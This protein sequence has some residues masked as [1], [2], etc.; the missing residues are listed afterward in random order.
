MRVTVIGDSALDVTVRPTAP[1][2]A[3]GDVPARIS[4]SPGGQGGNVAVRLARAG[5]EVRLATAI[6][7][8]AAGRLLRE[9]LDADGVIVV[10]LAAA[11]SG[12]VISLL[13]PGG[14]RAML[15]DRVTLA[16]AGVAAACA[17]AD[18]V[19]CSAYP[20][21]DDATA[22]ALAE[23][24][25]ALPSATIVSAGGGSLP[26]DPAL[27]ERL[28]RRLSTAGVRLL[29]VSREEASALLAR[30]LPSLP[31]A[32]DALAGAFLSVIAVV[33]GAAA[34]SAAAGPGFALSVPA[35]EPATPMVDA[36]GAGDAYV[37][38]LI[39][40]LAASDWPPDAA[41]LRDAMERGTRAGGLVARV[42]GAQGRTEDEAA[43]R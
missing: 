38:A 9:A 26:D 8:D 16:P 6:A 29:V 2:R 4:L 20:L 21:A 7:D 13:D 39:V 34:G 27:A 10:R 37:A 12:L 43:R 35:V 15:S 30:P 19:H 40:R 22:D 33:T 31:A 1:P 5:L 24:L 14:E 25:G 36:T 41:T 42:V 23:L 32:A 17:A 11:R 3:G 28:R 18:W